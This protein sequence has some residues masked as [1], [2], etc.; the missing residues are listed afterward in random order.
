[1][2]VVVV[3]S[4]IAG[5]CAWTVSISLSVTLTGLSGSLSAALIGLSA[6]ADASEPVSAGAEPLVRGLAGHA[7]RGA[8]VGPGGA[9]RASVGNVSRSFLSERLSGV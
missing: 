4:C 9:V 7:E 3:M 6:P 2:E 8:D 1:L 5:S